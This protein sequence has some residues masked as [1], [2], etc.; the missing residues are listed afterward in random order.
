[1]SVPLCG[2]HAVHPQRH[3]VRVPL[4]RA[5]RAI[6]AHL[7]HDHDVFVVVSADHAVWSA[8]LS[9]QVLRGQTQ[10]ALRVQAE[11]DQPTRS[12]HSYIVRHPFRCGAAVL[13]YCIHPN[14]V[15]AID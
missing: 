12:Q 8:L 5:L 14:Q 7:L 13:H 11:Q 2:G 3:Q 10:L 15:R 9:H 6:D 4:R 1:M